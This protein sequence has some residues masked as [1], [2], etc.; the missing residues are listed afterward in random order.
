M[1][2]RALYENVL[3]RGPPG[4]LKTLCQYISSL[5]SLCPRLLDRGLPCFRL[6]RWIATTFHPSRTEE[7]RPQDDI[8]RSFEQ[9]DLAK[10][11]QDDAGK[12][13]AIVAVRGLLG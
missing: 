10:F 9:I 11:V 1:I 4:T 8:F 13:S 5:D 12:V 2:R 7:T 3:P 6:L